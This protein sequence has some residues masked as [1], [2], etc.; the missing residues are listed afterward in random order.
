MKNDRELLEILDFPQRFKYLSVQ[1]THKINLSGGTVAELEPD[2]VS[3]DIPRLNYVNR[4]GF[5]PTF[6]QLKS[7]TNPE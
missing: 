3:T 6:H 2:D 7:N 4:H 1:F 5:A